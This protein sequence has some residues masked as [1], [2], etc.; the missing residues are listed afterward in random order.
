MLLYKSKTLRTNHYTILLKA[1]F[2]LVT[3]L[4]AINYT[5]AQ[6]PVANF[7]AS[8]TSGCAALTISFT[9]QS[10]GNPTN[11]NWEFSNGTLSNVQNPTVTFT[12]PG[13]YSVKLVVQNAAGISQLERVNYITVSPSPTANFTANM[14]LSCAPA[15]INF[16]DLSTTPSGSIT[17]WEWDF[18]DGT[19]S[20]LQNPSHTYNTVGFYTVSLTVYSSTG[21]KQLASASNYIRVVG[22]IETDF[23]WA[24]SSSCRPPYTVSF[25]NI[26]NGP[27]N[28][29]YSWDFGNSL[30]STLTNPS[31]VYNA[32]G[33]YNVRLNAQ[34][35]L[36]C[37]G[38]IVKAVTINETITD[39]TAPANICLNQPVTFQN[40]SSSPPLNSS[41]SF[42]DGTFSGQINPIK[43]F[44]AAGTYN[45][46]VINQYANC[47]DSVTKTITV[48]SRPDVNFT[49]D[50]STSCQN[51]FTVQFTDLT[52]GATSWLWNFGDG[53][54]STLQNPSHQYTANGSYT[55]SLTA[56]TSTG[57]SNTFVK[58]GYINI[59]PVSI[60]LNVPAG[61][62]VPF[63]YTP[64]ATIV[65]VD[66]IVSYAWDLGEPGAVSNQMNPPPHTYTNPGSY[67]ISL[68]VTTVTGCVQTTTIPG[69]VL[70]GVPPTV[71]FSA[72]PINGCASDTIN[73]T[74]LSTTTPGAVV[75]Y[76]WDFGDGG[77]SSLENPQHVFTDTGAVTVTLI[78]YN[79]RCPDSLKQNVQVLPPVALFNYTVDCITQQVTF[80]DSSLAD[81]AISPLTYLWQMG[82]PLN[83]QFNVQNPPP[84]TY[85][86]AGT[87]NVSLTVTNGPCS[88]TTTQQVVLAN[89]PADFT[90]NKNPVCKNETFT[91]TA[92]NSDPDNIMNYS[93]TVGGTTLPGTGR[94]VT[95]S[96][97]TS[98]TYSVTLTITDVNGCVSTRSI[99]NF[100]TVNGPSALFTPSTP[101]ACLEKAVQFTDQSTPAGSITQWDFDFGDG[102]TQSFTSAPFTHTY[103][104]L[105][106]FI[107]S[108]TV[109][110][111]AG[112]KDTYTLPTNLLVTSPVAG[113]RA[114]TFYCPNAPLQFVDTS[115][116]VGLTYLWNF[117]GTN[118]STLQN[119][120]FSFPLGDAD[121]T[122]SLII[123]DQSGCSD[124][125][126]KT[127]YV[128]IRSPKA[129]FTLLDSTTICPPLRTSFFLAASDYESISWSF[130]DGGMSLQSNPS[131]FYSNYGTFT[132][133]LY[134]MGPGGCIDS[135]KSSVTIHN[136]NDSEI[137]YGP[138]TTACN[139]LNVD[140]NL[141][142]PPGY[143]FHFSFGDGQIDSSQATTL[144]HLYSRPGLNTP[145]IILMD[146][147][148]GCT[149]VINGSPRID[150]MGAVPLFGMNKQEL[151]DNGP[152]VFTDFT[153]KNEPIIST[154]WDFDDG[155]T[156]NVQNPTHNFTAP[157]QYIVTLNI[158]TESNCSSSYSDTVLVY[159]TPQPIIT[160]RDTI[161]VT[162][163]ETFNGSIAV[164]D[165]LTEWLWNFGNG[166]TANTQ[167]HTI[168]YNTAGDYSI[169]LITSNLLGCSDTIVKS[170]HVIPPP[171]ATPVQDPITII[172][173]AGADL[174][175]DYT[176]NI[177]SW[178]WTPNTRLNCNNCPT[179]FASPQSTTTYEL[180]IVDVYGC[181][182]RSDITVNVICNNQNFFVPNTFS[183]N[184]DGQND[185]FY[186][187]GS[188]LFRIKSMLIFNRW[189][190]VV[191]ER[192]DFPPNDASNGW[193][194][195]FKGQKASADVYIYTM[196]I[197]CDNNT[198]IPV[199]G[200][201]T[202]LR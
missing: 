135:A 162:I 175:M 8:A 4:S 68:T 50:D 153:T 11:W 85:P 187:R 44:L 47:T 67:T 19:T 16:T 102:N 77:T 117:D 185:M 172:G 195:T 12:L 3:G 29:S 49:A 32:A 140:F 138:T 62:C 103:D 75:T 145:A 173:G 38:S 70:T 63:T 141:V 40:N 132:P 154:L 166:Q 2:L 56:T 100:I 182:N 148:S 86:G 119:P 60:G 165:T 37:T 94:S 24:L 101:G 142:V 169:Q 107:V 41:W 59:R 48:N 97:P 125:V 112:C 177:T 164:A 120:Q 152:V 184:G 179:P 73:F 188:G 96:I 28:I 13:T 52:A 168:T 79:N 130:G 176:G 113:F 127:D 191:Y 87:Y 61:G 80:R 43:T 10:T 71:N 157:G 143:K 90:I 144:S 74:N 116:G 174:L 57:C 202:L 197:L 22:G 104:L 200:N 99:N 92:T 30:T 194:G 128:S 136:P 58:P 156:S 27:G 42:G 39:F 21:C 147:A 150:V 35:D 201:V 193:N 18:G 161:C 196:E 178:L 189:G 66:A 180:E 36:G 151:C 133:T 88:Y 110:D 109:T 190:Q 33:T 31:T 137:N 53:N 115:S 108:M 93:W 76:L 181:R 124:T 131:Y 198:V 6:A 167:N 7:T 5:Y 192:K 106:G 25:Q 163:P 134:A 46:K 54:T 171:T 78:V 183:P 129:A 98:G 126:T 82:D 45:V 139:S 118:T 14:R 158:T 160:G 81:P 111:N 55:V 83:T 105:G 15:V 146:T 159:R 34:S 91:L 20:T 95:H 199:K 84:F 9:D 186:P 121:Y 23:E 149:V 17:A 114:D 51:P 72:A 89:E 123:T 1:A 122:I 64:Q 69:G 26:S 170:V 65:T 155:T